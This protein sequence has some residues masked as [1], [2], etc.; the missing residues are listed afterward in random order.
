L[1]VSNS[2]FSPGVLNVTVKSVLLFSAIKT[3]E[4]EKFVKEHPDSVLPIL[5]SCYRIIKPNYQNGG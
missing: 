2:I 1:H 3:G 4:I 5:K